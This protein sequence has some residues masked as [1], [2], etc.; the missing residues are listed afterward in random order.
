MIIYMPWPAQDIFKQDNEQ[1]KYQ[2]IEVQGTKLLVEPIAMDQ[3]RV[4]RVLSTDPQDYL[5]TEFQPGS[6]LTFTP[7][8]K[9]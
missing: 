3:C 9:S 8:L 5:K 2:E 6:E 7:V 4:V 1:Y